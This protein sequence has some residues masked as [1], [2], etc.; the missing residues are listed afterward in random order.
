MMRG[1]LSGI[2]ILIGC[3]TGIAYGHYAQQT[4]LQNDSLNEMPDNPTLF[5]SYGTI[6]S[7]DRLNKTI[8]LDIPSPYDSQ[9]LM[10]LQ[11][12][13]SGTQLVSKNSTAITAAEIKEGIP[14]TVWI[15]RRRGPLYM[16]LLRL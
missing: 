4:L 1:I 6:R 3:A 12:T 5:I 11:A 9:K 7:V 13:Y 16:T 2:I 14:A 10:A 8:T 15:A